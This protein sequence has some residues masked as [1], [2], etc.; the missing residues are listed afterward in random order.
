M[1]LRNERYSHTPS[2]WFGRIKSDAIRDSNKK[3][4]HSFRHTFIDYM[5]NHLNLQGN[6]L[7]KAL[8]G[9]TDREV[10]S[11]VYG[12]S[13]KVEDLNQIVQQVEFNI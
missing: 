2:K 10:T 5:F 7:L 11:G 8:V 6:P 3:S 1:E 12:S 13:F 4:F 9:H